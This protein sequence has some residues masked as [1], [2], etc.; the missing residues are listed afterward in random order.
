MNEDPLLVAWLSFAGIVVTGLSGILVAVIRAA[1]G[2]KARVEVAEREVSFQTVAL[3]FTDLVYQFGKLDNKIW[4]LLEETEIDRVLVLRAYN[5]RMDPKW[6]TA[7]RQWR[8]RGQ[9]GMTYCRVELDEDY[10]GRLR[11]LVNGG[12][13]LVDT[14][15]ESEAAT[16]IGRIYE[17]EGVQ[18]AAWYFVG[19]K[20]ISESPSSV[21]ITYVSAATHGDEPLKHGSLMRFQREVVDLLKLMHAELDAPSPRAGGRSKKT[22]AIDL[23]SPE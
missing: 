19:M 21:M 18:H 7:V 23:R 14:Q 11:K 20:E 1:R 4:Q 16:L 15:A 3:S 9:R 17:A 2:M 6:T 12:D 10:V 8:A 13:V 5:G 22:A